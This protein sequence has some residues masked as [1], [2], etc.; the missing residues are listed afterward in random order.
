MGCVLLDGTVLNVKWTG[1][2]PACGDIPAELNSATVKGSFTDK[3]VKPNRV[4][5]YRVSA[6]DWSG[7]ESSGGN[8]GKD[9]QNIPAI[10]TFTYDAKLPDSPTVLPCQPESASVC[11]LTVRWI[12]AFDPSLVDGFVVFRSTAINERYRQV[13]PL[14]KGNE[15]SDKSAIRNTVYWYRVQAINKRGN[16]ST[17]SQP[18]QYEY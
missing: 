13:S 17:P 8:G 6:L 5:W 3:T 14:I 12:P 10:S 18:V 4:Y 2:E 7:N 1:V 16:L 15:F 9:L 11:G